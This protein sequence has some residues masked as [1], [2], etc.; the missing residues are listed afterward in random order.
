MFVRMLES[1]TVVV[2][3]RRLKRAKKEDVERGRT[4]QPSLMNRAQG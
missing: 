2:N 1:T 3:K 4:L